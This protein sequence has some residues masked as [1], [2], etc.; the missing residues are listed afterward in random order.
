MESKL[1][2]I[3]VVLVAVIIAGSVFAA[4]DMEIGPF[5]EDEDDKDDNGNNNPQVD[6]KPIAVIE[7]NNTQPVADDLVMFDGSGSY[8][9]EGRNIT[10]YRWNFDD[11]DNSDNMSVNHSF[12]S[13][14]LYNVTLTVTDEDGN[15]NM[16]NILIGVVYRDH[17]DGTT[18][19]NAETFD[20]EM[21][22]MATMIYVNTTL[23]NGNANVGDNNVTVSLYFAGTLMDENTMEISGGG[24]PVTTRFSNQTNLTAGTWTWELIVNDSGLNCDLDWDVDV[25]IA[26]I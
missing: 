15:F 9:K 18:N 3:I 1:K 4:Y 22:E 25:V 23:E 2:I 20:F 8:G 11:G 21:G 5:E 13:A 6:N 10:A 17:Q 24:G 14:G 12:I 26:Y 7:A 16:S 19:G